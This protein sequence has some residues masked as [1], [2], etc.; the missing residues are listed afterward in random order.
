MAGLRPRQAVVNVQPPNFFNKL[1][2]LAVNPW[3]WRNSGG[4][5]P[6]RMS[7]AVTA[8]IIRRAGANVSLFYGTCFKD[9]M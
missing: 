2:L 1:I 4:G 3:Q 8:V 5:T 9:F 7:S 6:L